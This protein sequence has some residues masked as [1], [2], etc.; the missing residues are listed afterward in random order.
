MRGWRK[1]I[2]HS[3]RE[4][5]KLASTASGMPGSSPSPVQINITQDT[6]DVAVAKANVKSNLA[7]ATVRAA[8][9]K[10]YRT[11]QTWA[12]NMEYVRKSNEAVAEATEKLGLVRE[13][14]AQLDTGKVTLVSQK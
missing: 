5:A 4:L 7:S 6:P 10:L 13:K 11:Q 1:K 12:I 14:I 2:S 8:A 3:L 9:E